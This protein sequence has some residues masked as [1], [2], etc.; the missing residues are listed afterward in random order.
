MEANATRL[1]AGDRLIQYSWWCPMPLIH[2]HRLACSDPRANRKEVKKNKGWRKQVECTRVRLYFFF[3]W[4]WERRARPETEAEQERRMFLPGKKT[5]LATW[6]CV[7]AGRSEEKM[8]KQKKKERK[9]GPHIYV[10]PRQG[11]PSS[12]FRE[13]E[14]RLSLSLS[15]CLHAADSI[16]FA[17]PV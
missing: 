13:Q 16:F 6:W 15:L 11:K 12:I 2:S 1:V 3:T 8:R 17:T 14:H 4:L 7:V 10:P 9:R 5:S